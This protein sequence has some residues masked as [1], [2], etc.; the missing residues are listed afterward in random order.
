MLEPE[1]LV[2]VPFGSSE[3]IVHGWFC[4]FMRRD[5]HRIEMWAGTATSASVSDSY[6]RSDPASLGKAKVLY[7]KH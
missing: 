2:Q 4:E 5:A 7:P 3:H 1:R 6:G